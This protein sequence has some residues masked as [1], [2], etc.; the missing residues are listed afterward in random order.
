[1]EFRGTAATAEALDSAADTMV[2]AADALGDALDAGPT[3]RARPIGE[4]LAL[5]ARADVQYERLLTAAAASA[6]RIDAEGLYD[7]AEGID[8]T[9]DAVHDICQL[10]EAYQVDRLPDGYV[11]QA[12]DLLEMTSV[13]RR[14]LQ[15]Q[16]M[17]EVIAGWRRVNRGNGQVTAR[18]RII[19]AQLLDGSTDPLTAIKL[20]DIAE[21]VAACANSVEQLARTVTLL[22]SRD[23]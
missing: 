11:V 12:D 3:A 1:M 8:T 14:M 18:H 7:I 13:V 16:S 6:D 22:A 23:S 15:A 2:A 4:V 20:K 17:D 21:S 5:E 19:V 10:L 9:V